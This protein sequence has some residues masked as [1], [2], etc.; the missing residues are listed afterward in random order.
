MRIVACADATT[1]ARADVGRGA[2]RDPRILAPTYNTIVYTLTVFTFTS[3]FM[4]SELFISV[5]YEYAGR[6][7]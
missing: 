7:I 2:M 6:S 5:R 1:R 4:M 3:Y